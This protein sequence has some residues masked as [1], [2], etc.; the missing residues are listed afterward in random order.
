MVKIVRQAG[1]QVYDD[2]RDAR[3]KLLRVED[4][5]RVAQPRPR[6][7]PEQGKAAA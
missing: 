7:E 3:V 4:V 2:P 6:Q 1:I 5:E